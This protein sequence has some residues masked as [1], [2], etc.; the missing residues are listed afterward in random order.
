MQSF[1]ATADAPQEHV[2]AENGSFSCRRKEGNPFHVEVQNCTLGRQ[3]VLAFTEEIQ[4]LVLE[5]QEDGM[6][7]LKSF[8]EGGCFIC[9]LSSIF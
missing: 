5:K 6:F 2:F 3:A 9:N 1:A 8:Y 4:G 7:L